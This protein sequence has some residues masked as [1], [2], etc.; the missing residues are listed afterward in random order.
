MAHSHLLRRQGPPVGHRLVLSQQRAVVFVGGAGG[1]SQGTIICWKNF[2]LWYMLIEYYI[3]N[4]FLPGD[5]HPLA[6]S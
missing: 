6:R 4:G 3:V 1:A 5:V 2:P